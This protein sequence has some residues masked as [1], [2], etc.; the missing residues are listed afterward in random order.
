MMVFNARSIR[1]KMA[2]FRSM[3]ATE[4]LDI[5]GITE[6]WIRTDTRDFEAEFE[7]L[8]F[9]MFRKDR[10]RRE[11]GG[12]LLYVK[13]HL[14]PI[15]C[16]IE[17]GHELLGIELT[18]LEKH[19]HIFLVY[20]PPHQLTDVDVSLY[21]QLNNLIR[22]RL[23]IV[24]GDFNCRVNWEDRTSDAD[25]RR[26]INFADD[27]FLTQWVDQPTR[28]NNILDLVFTTEDNLVTDLRVEEALGTSDHNVIRFRVSV[29]SV[30]SVR[31]A[32]MKLDFRRADFPSF[33]RSLTGLVVPREEDIECV[34][35]TFRNQFMD[36]QNS[37]IPM[38][39]VTSSGKQQPKWFNREIA[40]AINSRKRA[41]RL[42]KEQ[43]SLSKEGIYVGLR[44]KVKGLIKTAKLN[45]EIR[46][47]SLCKENPKEFFAHVNSRKPIKSS[48]GPLKDEQGILLGSDEDIGRV[49]NRF[50]VS[51]FTRENTSHIPETEIR[52]NGDTPLSEIELTLEEVRQK[53][54]KLN[55][56]K[57]PGPDGFLPRVVKEVGAEVAPHLLTIFKKTLELGRV[58]E[59]W[60][61]ANVTPI[62]KKGPRDNPGNYRPISLTSIVGKMLESIIADRMVDHL[63]SHN[64]I[65]DSQH[66][67]RHHR[68]CLTNLLDFFHNMLSVY[69]RTKGIDVLYLDFQKAFDKVPHIRLMAKVRALGITGKVAEWIECW[70]SNRKQRVVINGTASE[71]AS[72]TSGV[73]Q[74]SVLGPLLFIIYINDIDV[75]LVS[76]ISKFADDT[77]LGANAVEL[78][79]VQQ[80]QSDLDKIGEWSQKWQMPFNMG[81][82]KV[83]HIGHRNLHADYTMLGSEVE[84]TDL[85][86]DLGV[87]I[88]SDL[89][90]SKQCIEVEKK[91]QKL[92]GYI[93]RQFKYR[94]KEIVLTLYNS[95]V[96]PHLEYAVQF[97]SPAL[98]KD[99]DRLE[100]VQARATKLIPSIRKKGYQ[101]RLQDLGLYTLETRRLRGQ[102]IEVFKILKGFNNVDYR[103]FFTLN[104]NQTRN[105][106]LKIELKRFST[107][108]CGNFFTYKIGN[109][110][111]GLPSEVVNSS[112]VEQFKNRL[113]KILH[114]LDS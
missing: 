6:S 90:F 79:G 66:G 55:K 21:D 40:S 59:D 75:G 61:V 74:G 114:T 65:M 38:K 46:V 107:S 112:S 37:C 32:H 102:L 97:W 103:N 86:K 4:K 43:P 51:V 72:V 89:K 67:F 12:V 63:E 27:N 62:F 88:S 16:K 109:V 28:G 95:L 7:L 85:E 26:L 76:K 20:R 25:G 87:L 110:W 100:R 98:R 33:E 64:L 78:T 39:R 96:R 24:T 73:P 108:L 19:V 41:Y 106:G 48:I 34:W 9:K 104:E 52:Y 2:E 22:D 36:I 57:S 17:S 68:S 101:R 1:N 13:D 3:V 11:G 30:D 10:V 91:A 84:K 70:L 77:K 35:S 23:S 44:K 82:C 83:M 93:K 105:N 15:E 31:M 8:G 50:F 71:W 18:G 47:A 49:L 5:I 92:L 80:L 45:E 56:S 81:K 99:I 42:A 111:N 58:P 54:I 60:K 94:N 29:P 69:D 14:N 53:I 113:D